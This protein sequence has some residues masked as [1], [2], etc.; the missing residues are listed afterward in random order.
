MVLAAAETYFVVV[1]GSSDNTVE[2]I[3]INSSLCFCLVNLDL[4]D[5]QGQKKT[6][7]VPSIDLACQLSSILPL[8]LN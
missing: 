7:Q 2:N 6:K 8:A 3:M 4:N 1:S 5:P